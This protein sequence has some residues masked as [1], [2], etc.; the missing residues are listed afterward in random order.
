MQ[1]KERNK[2]RKIKKERKT[3]RRRERE[4]VVLNVRPFHLDCDQLASFS[5]R[6]YSLLQINPNKILPKTASMFSGTNYLFILLLLTMYSNTKVMKRS[7]LQL[8]S[9]KPFLFAF[10]EFKSIELFRLIKSCCPMRVCYL[11]LGHVFGFWR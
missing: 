6:N 1:N 7:K 3:K 9:F 11:A 8:F 2:E 5:T 10:S 4:N